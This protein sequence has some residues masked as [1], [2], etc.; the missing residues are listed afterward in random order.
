MIEVKPLNAYEILNV[1]VTA[2]RAEIRAAYRALARGW[3]PD[4]FMQGPERDWA[5]DKMAEIN[6]AYR[7]CLDGSGRAA[8]DERAD[9][10]RLKQIEQMIDDGKYLTARRMLMGFTTRCAEWN[11]LFGAVLMRLRET[12]KAVI[13]LSVAAHQNPGSAKYARALRDAQNRQGGVARRFADRI[14]RRR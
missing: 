12:E 10:E 14:V 8:S 6:A 9:S 11:Y 3:H 7:E 4:R 13:Y 2:T 5:N 1:P